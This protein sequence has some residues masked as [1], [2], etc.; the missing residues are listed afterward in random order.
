MDGDNLTEHY[1]ESRSQ[2]IKEFHRVS[3]TPVLGMW[4]GSYL[5]WDGSRG[6]LTGR[7]TVFRSGEEASSDFFDASVIDRELYPV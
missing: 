1:G 7:A 2:R 6:V 3:D 4:E 5:E